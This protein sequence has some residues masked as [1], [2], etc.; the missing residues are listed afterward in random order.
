LARDTGVVVRPAD[1]VAVAD[2]VVRVFSAEGD[3]TNRAKARLKYVLD[4]LGFEAFLTR[5]EAVLG[6]KLDRVDAADVAP[7]PN[8]DRTAHLGFHA[9]VQQ[10]L[11]YAG[12]VV[13]VGRLTTAQMRGIAAIAR[14]LGDGDVRLTVWQNLLVSGIAAERAGEVTARLT[15]LGLSAQPTSIRA[16]LVACTGMTGCKF[17]NAHTKENALDIAAH[18]EARLAL[19]GPVNIHLTGCPNSC[20]QHYIG[21][22]GLIGVKVPVG[23]DGDTVE[24][25]DIVVGGGFAENAAIGRELWKAVPA[26]AA[27]VHVEALLRAYLA[28]RGGPEESFQAFTLRVGVDDLKGCAPVGAAL[29]AAE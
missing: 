29:E 20:A 11:V 13:P 1:C 14:D 26:D 22:I 8:T 27:A 6:K 4:R 23:S 24:G 28:G 7:R 17:A 15:G 16:G 25:Y 3:R 18:V 2:A 12:V 21:D 19:D 10:G 9:Q 5:V